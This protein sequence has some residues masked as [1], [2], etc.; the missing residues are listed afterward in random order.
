[1]Q[2]LGHPAEIDLVP[3]GTD[4]DHR[5]QTWLQVAC[6]PGPD[7]LFATST[8]AQTLNEVQTEL[9]QLRIRQ[10][11]QQL[12]L[13]HLTETLASTFPQLAGPLNLL[14]RPTDLNPGR[15]GD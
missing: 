6:I 13:G 14:M 5:A 12:Q 11:D 2:Y 1:M 3:D 8:A 10:R 15:P 4:H 7:W 9:A